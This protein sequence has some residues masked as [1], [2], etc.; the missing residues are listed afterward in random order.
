M[1]RFR[2]NSFVETTCIPKRKL[3]EHITR[4]PPLRGIPGIGLILKYVLKY[5]MRMLSCVSEVQLEH[6]QFTLCG[7]A[8]DQ[9][10]RLQRK[11]TRNGSLLQERNLVR[12]S[13]TE[14]RGA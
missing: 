2:C 5:V 6:F 14:D 9:C 13:F 4:I 10:E 3:Q 12:L 11:L 7:S 8:C 1:V